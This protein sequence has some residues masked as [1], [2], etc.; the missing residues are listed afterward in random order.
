MQVTNIQRII[1]INHILK[2][3]VTFLLQIYHKMCKL[4][5]ST[6]FTVP[7]DYLDKKIM[8]LQ[9]KPCDAAVNYC[10]Y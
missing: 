7:L 6:I 4:C 3:W 9:Q 8:L 2:K 1:N 5:F 10:R